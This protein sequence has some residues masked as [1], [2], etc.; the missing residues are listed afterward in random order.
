M[1]TLFDNLSKK[2]SKMVTN[3]YST[4]FSLGIRFLAKKFHDPIYAVYGFVRFADE[5]VDTFHGYNKRELLED[6]RKDT[7]KAIKQG[8]SL[9]P[10]LN[11]FQEVVNKY[12]VDHELIDTFLYSMEMDLDDREYDQSAYEKYILGSAEV[13]GLMC[14]KVFVEGDPQKYE[15]LKPYAMKLGSAFQKINFLRD[16]KVDTEYLGRIYFPQ[17]QFTQMD[18]QTKLEIER[19]IEKDFAVGYEGIKRLPKDARFGV[20]VA[21]IYYSNLLHKIMEMPAQQIMQERVRIP[22]NEKYALFFGSYLRHSFN[23]L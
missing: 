13:V 3:A 9:N 22:N 21:Y 2:T 1:K 19:D 12:E 16:Y 5:I 18:Q 17:L 14:L 23:L 11:A 6:F 4:S 20:Y 7:Y 15:E 10:I 8:I